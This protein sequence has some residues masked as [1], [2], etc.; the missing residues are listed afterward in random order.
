MN[1]REQLKMQLNMIEKN[2]T[3]N[4]VLFVNFNLD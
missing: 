3:E 2:Y 1:A 4:W